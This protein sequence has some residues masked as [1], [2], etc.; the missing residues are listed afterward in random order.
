MEKEAVWPI[1]E[2]CSPSFGI[3]FSCRLRSPRQRTEAGAYGPGTL[4][5]MSSFAGSP[6]PGRS[7]KFFA[8]G[9]GCRKG[10]SCPFSH[11]V[12]GSGTPSTGKGHRGGKGK[13]GGKGSKGDKGGKG[14]KGGNGG[15]GGKSNKKKRPAPAEVIVEPVIR[16]GCRT[17]E[18]SL[19]VDDVRM[20]GVRSGGRE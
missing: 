1:A 15:R 14:G 17:V 6:T 20:A 18:E 9:K 10:E 7:C 16:A 13:R 11:A 3:R 12:G 4:I 8:S 2:L 5:S 19:G